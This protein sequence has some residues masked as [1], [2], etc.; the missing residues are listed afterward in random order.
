MDTGRWKKLL[1]SWANVL[2]VCD[3]ELNTI[4]DFVTSD[5]FPRLVCKLHGKQAQNVRS[6]ECAFN[7]FKG[8][9]PSIDIDTSQMNE[10]DLIVAATLSLVHCSLNLVPSD[11]ELQEKVCSL[12]HEHQ[13]LLKTLLEKF[14]TKEKSTV[15]KEM[16]ISEITHLGEDSNISVTSPLSGTP[17][18]YM[19]QLKVSKSSSTQSSTKKMSKVQRLRH[20]IE[21]LTS[22]Q[23]ELQEDLETANQTI[24]KLT[25]TVTNKDN[26]IARL[27]ADLTILANNEEVVSAESVHRECKKCQNLM[28]KLETYENECMELQ[29]ELSDVTKKKESKF[30]TLQEEIM[31]YEMKLKQ[32]QEKEE[33]LIEEINHF[34]RVITELKKVNQEQLEYLN[35]LKPK[36]NDISESSL[37][38]ISLPEDNL[39]NQ[40]IDLQIQELR[41]SLEEK[42]KQLTNLNEEMETYKIDLSSCHEI[43]R[44]H[45]STIKILTEQKDVLENEILDLKDNLQQADKNLKHITQENCDFEKNIKEIRKDLI[46]KL[47]ELR[48]METLKEELNNKLDEQIEKYE[49]LSKEKDVLIIVMAEKN[50]ELFE[51][52]TNLDNVNQLNST[53]ENDMA[54]KT[55]II[56]SLTNN[57]KELNE[58]YDS[59]KASNCKLQ[60]NIS[61]LESEIKNYKDELETA[62]KDRELLKHKVITLSKDLS[63]FNEK[64]HS[65]K[66]SHSSLEKSNTYLESEIVNHK[67]K[68]ETVCEEKELLKQKV[69]SLTE[70]LTELNEKYYSLSNSYY[71]LQENNVSLEN[72]I[73]DHKVNLESV[74]EDREELKQKINTL[75]KELSEL[76][77][78]YDLQANSTSSLQE[79]NTYLENEV[80]NYKIKFETLRDERGLLKQKIDLLSK[81]HAEL[82]TEYETL[83]NNH[84]TLQEKLIHLE[85]EIKNHKVNLE[86]VIDERESLKEKVN[87]LE[88][89]MN[90]VSLEK[91]KLVDEN[92]ILI[93]QVNDHMMSEN[94]YLLQ[95]QEL[96]SKLTLQEHNIQL[97]LKEK[98][99]LIHRISQLDDKVT[100]KT[101]EIKT[102]QETINKMQNEKQMLNIKIENI[103]EELIETSS[104]ASSSQ[105]ELVQVKEELDKMVG[106]HENKVQLLE[107][108]CCQGKLLKQICNQINEKMYEILKGHGFSDS[109]RLESLQKYVSIEKTN[110]SDENITKTPKDSIKLIDE[111]TTFDKFIERFTSHLENLDECN[112]ILE[113]Y[114]QKLEINEQTIAT[115]NVDKINLQKTIENMQNKLEQMS[116]ELVEKIESEKCLTHENRKL[117]E[118]IFNLDREKLELLNNIID[119]NNQVDTLKIDTEKLEKVLLEKE[120]LNENRSK[121]IEDSLEI[122]KLM[123]E[124]INCKTEKIQSV[125]TEIVQLKNEICSLEQE[126]ANKAKEMLTLNKDN[127]DLKCKCESLDTEFKNLIEEFNTKTELF[128]ELET[129]QEKLVSEKNALI[130]ELQKLTN[131]QGEQIEEITRLTNDNTKVMYEIESIN[132]DLILVKQDLNN[133]L[134]TKNNLSEKLDCI[135]NEL[136]IKTS[137]LQSLTTENSNLKEKLNLTKEELRSLENVNEQQKETIKLLTEEKELSEEIITVL[138]KH[139]VEQLNDWEI[140]E[141][142]FEDE[143]SYQKVEQDLKKFQQYLSKRELELNS[144]FDMI[145][146][147]KES[148]INLTLHVFKSREH[149]DELLKKVKILEDKNLE[150]TDDVNL[151]KDELTKMTEKEDNL[152]S[153]IKTLNAD[154]FL[155]NRDLRTKT[156]EIKLLKDAKNKLLDETN[157][158]KKEIESLETTG[159]L[160]KVTNNSLESELATAKQ[161]LTELLIEQNSIL[162]EIIDVKLEPFSQDS[163]PSLCVIIDRFKSNFRTFKEDLAKKQNKIMEMETSIST[164]PSLE[165]EIKDILRTFNDYKGKVQEEMASLN[166]EYDM[167]KEKYLNAKLK[168][169]KLETNIG[170]IEKNIRSE[171]EL[172]LNK[173]KLKMKQAYKEK[174]EDLTFGVPNETVDTLK[175][176]LRYE[177]NKAMGLESKLLEYSDKLLIAQEENRRL[178]TDNFVKP[179]PIAFQ[180]AT[181]LNHAQPSLKST[182]IMKSHSEEFLT[183]RKGGIDNLG[184]DLSPDDSIGSGRR[185]SVRSLPRGIGNIF[186]LSAGRVFPAA[187]EAGEV[188]DDRCLA[189][190][191]AGIVNLPDSDLCQERMSILQLRNSLC[192]PHLKSSYPVETQFLNPADLKEDDIKISYKKPSPP[193]TNKS[194]GAKVGGVLKEQNRNPQK[195]STPNRIKALFG[196]KPKDENSPVARQKS[197]RR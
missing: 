153:N 113:E 43:I 31:T 28:E 133:T 187:E 23:M 129:A 154:L 95:V 178:M 7:F 26:E 34:N 166:K 177:R 176:E 73:Q 195:M 44:E 89:Y 70:N 74:S 139:L 164:I 11:Q 134:H 20:Q 56:N 132:S 69:D 111:L 85:S 121:E 124:E 158:L 135:N 145:K 61:C 35:E 94:N 108:L 126:L 144:I 118:Q 30:S 25:D 149:S 184:H 161:N 4:E 183:G 9:Y 99:G 50:N 173:L 76:N 92:R 101:C 165:K 46:E 114:A 24:S 72:E 155:K 112:K 130:A 162:T 151:L 192:P 65:L 45:T 175:E 59:V 180:S 54:R 181:S 8:I 80:E 90:I 191:K 49:I 163:V 83:K 1:L 82:S 179:A 193:T 141:E 27:K 171:Y 38:D 36:R 120:K 78:K 119:L 150:L 63:D 19:L 60:E 197:S 32:S 159:E 104:L 100:L 51:L 53:L 79:N 128:N 137:S 188:F 64:F 185:S 143:N 168:I 12:P 152:K 22:V 157:I 87:S 10:N 17:L 115:L 148:F 67:A 170:E 172:K 105:D 66:S 5:F 42:D 91:E 68:L 40:V 122:I 189:D 107:K 96:K 190:L 127:C 136:T 57:L 167:V 160:M 131:L 41:Q 58:K 21:Q 194:S 3:E 103:K 6:I 47:S 81:E 140:K 39:G 33:F 106:K 156:S 62:I 169:N 15:T 174:L 84:S 93:G 142:K 98:N 182:P 55:K 109:N 147:K 102:L 77:V 52:K 16:I 146:L 123:K 125:E 48:S 138:K 37:P 97:I 117:A 88:E 71:S 13:C 86:A 196:Y 116:S 110:I 29:E 14:I 75:S 186:S 2:R 18:S